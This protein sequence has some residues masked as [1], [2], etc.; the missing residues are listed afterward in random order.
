MDVFV[1]T[2]L[3]LVFFHALADFP[4]QGDF[5]AKAKNPLT[6]LPGIPW[7]WAMTM[8]TTIHAGAVLLVTGSYLLAGVELVMHWIIDDNK[9]RGHFG[10]GIDQGLHVMCK[11]FWALGV[12]MSV[13]FGE[14]LP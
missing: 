11:A 6:P 12:A 8:H 5:L 1:T 4:L 2:F 3:A 10:F 13:A 9:C 7:A 14:P